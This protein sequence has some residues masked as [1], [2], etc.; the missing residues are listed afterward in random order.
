MRILIADDHPII[1]VALGE[2]LKAALGDGLASLE[3][4]ADSDT[5]LARYPDVA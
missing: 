5:L 2:I 4:V 3:T 1:C